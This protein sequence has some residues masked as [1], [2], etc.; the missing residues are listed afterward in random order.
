MSSNTQHHSCAG[1][2]F[3]RARKEVTAASSP[4]AAPVPGANPN[5]PRFPPVRQTGRSL[6]GC[7]NKLP[8]SQSAVQWV[9]RQRVRMGSGPGVL[10]HGPLGLCSSWPS[11]GPM[12]SHCPRTPRS[13]HQGPL[14]A[15]LITAQTPKPALLPGSLRLLG[16]RVRT[17]HHHG[18]F[19]LPHQ[20]PTHCTVSQSRP[21]LFA[22][23]TRR[24]GGREGR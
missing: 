1:P 23:W 13:T 5:L 22:G 4:T 8:G 10:S 2:G 9:Y 19:T 17:Q 20:P 16:C 3:T 11:K 7:A 21:N 18:L 24:K 14:L 12:S 15:P 6:S